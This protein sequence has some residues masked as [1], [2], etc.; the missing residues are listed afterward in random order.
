MD[1]PLLAKVFPGWSFQ[2]VDVARG[3]AVPPGTPPLDRLVVAVPPAPPAG[4]PGTPPR[5]AVLLDGLDD[6]LAFFRA[7][8]PRPA[9][10]SA[11]ADQTT[12]FASLCRY[13]SWEGPLTA[14][15]DGG[16]VSALAVGLPG[17]RRQAGQLTLEWRADGLHVA[18]P[19]PPE[20]NGR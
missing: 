7:P 3:A 9:D 20:V 12:A 6:V 14:E 5:P 17:Q 1:P 2:A 19:R 13:D 4:A 11:A 10:A 16:F 15:R 18:D 8:A